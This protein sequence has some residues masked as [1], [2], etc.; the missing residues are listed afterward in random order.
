MQ[1]YFTL[2][3]EKGKSGSPAGA[4]HEVFIFECQSRRDQFRQALKGVCRFRERKKD[5]MGKEETFDTLE[6][7]PDRFVKEILPPLRFSL[8]L[9]KQCKDGNMQRSQ[10]QLVNITFINMDPSIRNPESKIE[11]LM[12]TR[13]ALSTISLIQFLAAYVQ[14]VV[15]QED[16]PPEPKLVKEDSD[17]DNDMVPPLQVFPITD[18]DDMKNV[19]PVRGAVWP[20]KDLQGVWFMAAED[21]TMKLDF[22]GKVYEMRFFTDGC[23]QRFRQHLACTLKTGEE[24]LDADKREQ[25]GKKWKV[26]PTRKDKMDEV[27]KE[28]K[29]HERNL[30]AHVAQIEKM[31]QLALKH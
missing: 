25:Q 13:D 21:P 10:A 6:T 12:L 17:S 14:E 2:W 30:D 29:T 18:M 3:W 7:G 16:K 9:R 28:L 24:D 23:R 11:V 15:G 26:Q 1:Q 27:K 19:M 8:W 22:G 31:T 5:K 4:H 20:I